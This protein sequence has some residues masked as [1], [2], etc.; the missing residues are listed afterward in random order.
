MSLTTRAFAFTDL[1]LRGD[2]R[3]VCGIAAPF[4]SPTTVHE[5]GRTFTEVI[6]RGAFARTIAERGDRVKLLALHDQRRLPL[7]RATTLR[8]DPG[9]L[10]MEARVSQTSAG[11][12]A[13][14][15]VRDGALDGFSIGFDLPAKTGERWTRDGTRE[16]L[17]VRLHE[18]SLV[19]FPAY[20]AALVS[21]VRA[22]T[23][24]RADRDPDLLRRRLRLRF[25]F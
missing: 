17:E 5:A 22:A 6:R 8:E 21:G 13:L 25:D 11:D 4:D 19:T 12:E 18:V 16:L 10:Y 20:A 14:E 23:G 15:L 3:T 2:G 9:G 7:G 24:Y 1:E